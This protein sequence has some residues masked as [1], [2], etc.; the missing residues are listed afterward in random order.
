MYATKMKPIRPRIFSSQSQARL[1]KS[2]HAENQGKRE[3]GK[4]G[5]DVVGSVI[6]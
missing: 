5:Q 6:K 2:A 3:E 1:P 4:E